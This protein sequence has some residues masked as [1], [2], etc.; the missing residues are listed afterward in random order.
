MPAGGPARRRYS[1][2]LFP[3]L[4]DI[5]VQPR[6]PVRRLSPEGI[7]NGH[8]SEGVSH[9]PTAKKIRYRHILVPQFGNRT[10]ATVLDYS[11]S[12]LLL[13]GLTEPQFDACTAPREVSTSIISFS[14]ASSVRSWLSDIT[15]LI[16][17][18]RSFEV[19]SLIELCS[20]SRRHCLRH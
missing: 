6:I 9:V 7:D 3:Y 4:E 13:D 18:I 1:L 20:G 15:Q 8:L 12:Q 11:L 2:A 16:S 5:L 14:A 19:H 17:R 10:G